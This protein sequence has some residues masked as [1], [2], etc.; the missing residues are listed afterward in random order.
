MLEDALKRGVDHVAITGDIADEAQPDVL[1]G[2]L[3][4]LKEIGLPLGQKCTVVIGNH[5]VVPFGDATDPFGIFETHGGPFWPALKKAVL[6]GNF[7]PTKLV[8]RGIQAS[9]DEVLK[10]IGRRRKRLLARIQKLEVDS[11]LSPSA[12]YPLGKALSPTVSLAAIDTTAGADVDWT[13]LASGRLRKGEMKAVQRFFDAE[14]KPIRVLLMH[15]SPV[16]TDVDSI[17][18]PIKITTQD[19]ANHFNKPNPFQATLFK[20]KFRLPLRFEA[21][22]PRA[23]RAM[24]VQAG[25]T[26]VLCGHLHAQ[27]TSFIKDRGK[28]CWVA[29]ASHCDGR[30]FIATIPLSGDPTYEKIKF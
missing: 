11:A 5:D 16:A 1:K 21:P 29:C 4:E 7:S 2:F 3:R 22:R 19:V 23:A 10:D 28:R 9:Y 18:L 26:V 30:Y 6:A 13:D 24:I 15:H 20:E 17:D 25:A 12:G 8:R 14:A 27:Q